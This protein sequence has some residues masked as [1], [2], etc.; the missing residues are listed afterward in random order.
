MSH[1]CTLK[2]RIQALILLFQFLKTSS[3][4]PDRFF[5][6]LYEV[7]F[8]EELKINSSC[9]QFYD[10]LYSALK[11]D[12]SIPRVKAFIKR[13]LQVAVHAEAPFAISSLLLVARLLQAHDGAISLV[14]FSEHSKFN[15]EDAEE[16]FKDAPDEDDR[17]F[18]QTEDLKRAPKDNEFLL[19]KNIEEK[20][21]NTG[22]YDPYKREPL[23]ANADGSLLFEVLLLKEHYHPTVRLYASK[24]IEGVQKNASLF[25]YNGNPWLDHSLSNFLD[26]ISFKKPKKV[27]EGKQNKMR[28]SKL[29]AP[30]SET[31]RDGLLKFILIISPSSLLMKQS[32]QMKNTLLNTSNTEFPENKRREVMVTLKMKK[33]KWML[34]PMKSLK[35]N[36]K[37]ETL[38][39]MMKMISWTMMVLKTA[40]FVC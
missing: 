8:V 26:R 22:E 23:Y 40:L 28:L 21:R 18:N 34:M 32:E 38:M 2:I 6:V 10:V 29:V 3:T 35:S 33:L 27:D 1:Q 31:V 36:S 13:V 17:L 37:M 9:Q 12:F 25:E 24:L 11:E 16:V 19:S 5:R 20:Q 15:N 14:K 30:I 39:T 4:L 7:L